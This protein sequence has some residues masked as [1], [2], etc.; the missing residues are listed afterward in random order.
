ML[1]VHP[2]SYLTAYKNRK[3]LQEQEQKAKE[4]EAG[5]SENKEEQN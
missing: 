3:F 4:S 1:P 5:K 2:K